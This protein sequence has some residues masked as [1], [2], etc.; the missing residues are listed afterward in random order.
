MSERNFEIVHVPF[1]ETETEERAS[2]L[3]EVSSSDDDFAIFR[4]DFDCFSPITWIFTSYFKIDRTEILSYKQ[5]FTS[6]RAA[7]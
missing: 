6:D 1:E 2:S 3:S 4:I 5:E 7:Q